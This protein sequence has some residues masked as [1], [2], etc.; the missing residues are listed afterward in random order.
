MYIFL[1]RILWHVVMET[2]TPDGRFKRKFS[3]VQE[4]FNEGE[5]GLGSNL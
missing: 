5:I 3:W 1:S 2:T 4:K